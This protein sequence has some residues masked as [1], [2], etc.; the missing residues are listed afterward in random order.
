MSSNA[1]VYT[2]KTLKPDEVTA[3]KNLEIHPR[4]VVRQ[5]MHPRYQMTLSTPS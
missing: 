3:T 1:M 2:K 5:Q 4:N